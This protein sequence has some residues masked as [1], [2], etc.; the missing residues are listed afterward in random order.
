M[1][2][3]LVPETM[4][5][6]DVLSV[7]SK[8]RRSIAVVVDEYGGTSGIMTVEDI[9]EELFGEIEDEHDNIDLLNK[10][11]SDNTFRFSA[12]LDVD[13]INETYKLNLPEEE[14]YETL[15]GLIVSFNEEIPK[16]GEIIAIQHFRFTITEASNNKIDAVELKVLDQ[17]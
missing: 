12:R 3:E 10:Q 8:K 13:A 5:A 7:L 6:K 11:I 17:D 15:G 1:P 14:N 16:K 4:L 9:V 2:V